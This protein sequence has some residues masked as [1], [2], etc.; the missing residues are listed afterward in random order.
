MKSFII[1]LLSRI[2]FWAIACLVVVGVTGCSRNTQSTPTAEPIVATAVTT[3]SLPTAVEAPAEQADVMPQRGP[4]G[5][6]GAGALF[7][8]WLPP[9]P[10]W[11]MPRWPR[12]RTS[13]CTFPPAATALFRW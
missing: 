1:T 7:L 6:G 13:T 5:S 3:E 9:P 11:T 4:G 10:T 2:T 12:H 8:R